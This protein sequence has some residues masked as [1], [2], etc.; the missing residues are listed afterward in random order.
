MP[1]FKDYLFEP[2]TQVKGRLVQAVTK[3]TRYT[4]GNFIAIGLVGAIGFP[5]YYVIWGFLFPQPYENLYLRLVGSLMFIPIILIRHWPNGWKSYF[6]FYWIAVVTYSLP[7]FFTF[8]LLR[9]DAS[10]VWG[11]SI[12]SAILLLFLV[13]DDWLA[14]N[15][16]FLLGSFLAWLAYAWSTADGSLPADY[17]VQLPIYLFALVTGSIFVHRG[18]IL[19]QER[20]QV[21]TAIG[22][23][24]AHELRTPLQGIQS[25]VAGLHRY[26]PALLQG[27]RC[28]QAHRLEVPPIRAAH[29]TALDSLLARLEHETAASHRFIDTLLVSAGKLKVDK[30]SFKQYSARECIETAIERYPFS[31]SEERRKVVLKP[32]GDFTFFG[33]EV[34]CSHIIFNLIKNALW[35]IHNTGKGDITIQIVAGAKENSVIFRDTGPGISPNAMPYIFD[36]FFSTREGGKGAGIGL[37]FCKLV[38]EA[39]KGRIGARSKPGEYTEFTL[40]F[41]REKDD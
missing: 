22:S 23:N 1:F 29:L 11:M 18:E 2:Y 36:Q 12:M 25:G 38:M 5:A 39:F 26:L 34:L 24:I 3:S 6:P 13:L 7:F 17:L 35:F 30:S 8:M 41:K 10:L 37:A 21:M 4:E 40:Y 9:N 16:I 28:A 19:H 27:Y 31:S 15:L 32:D 20:L 14:I 33:S